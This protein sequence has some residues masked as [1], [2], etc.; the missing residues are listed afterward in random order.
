MRGSFK[1]GEV[2]RARISSDQAVFA[3]L[4]RAWLPYFATTGGA[5]A[6]H[7][8]RSGGPSVFADVALCMGAVFA[9]ALCCRWARRRPGWTPRLPRELRGAVLAYAERTFRSNF[10]QRLSARVDRA[11]RARSGVVTLIELK[12]RRTHRHYLSDVI[13]LSAQR[14]A[15]MSETGESVSHHA[16]VLVQG[17][18]RR[19]THRVELLSEAQV[20]ALVARREAILSGM[21][22]PL[23]ACGSGLCAHCAF[24]IPCSRS[25]P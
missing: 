4:Q 1:K 22:Q 21:A 7:S 13:E 25:G 18:R 3:A 2:Y 9:V 12:T 20:L 17:P 10:P 24:A 16:Y 8:G 11:Y 19:S 14:L 6:H 23:H 15:L 5:R